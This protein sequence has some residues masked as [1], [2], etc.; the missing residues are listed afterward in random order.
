METPWVFCCLRCR[1]DFFASDTIYDAGS[2]LEFPMRRFLM[3]MGLVFGG[4]AAAML[5]A[6]AQ[7]DTPQQLQ[8]MIANGQAQTALN[9]LQQALQAHPTSGVAWYLT[10]EAQDSLGNESAARAALGN[11]EHFAP[12]LPFANQSDLAA[13]QAHLNSDP[14]PV[15]PV[16]SGISPALVGIIVVVGLFIV[17]R[18]FRRRRYVQPYGQGGFGP[19]YGPGGPGP[20]PYNQGPGMGGSGIGGSILGGLAAGAGFA[21]GE[22]VIGDMFGGNNNNTNNPVDPAWGGNQPMPDRDDG[23]QG[24]PGWDAG[25]TP[26]DG[27][28]FDPNNNW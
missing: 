14:A 21:A 28:N 12:G 20:Y 2:G 17:F 22:R 6:S 19:G 9:E 13:L 27:G 24:S 10:A 16:H 7:S 25:S 11:A 1:M 3:V 5:P 26:D 23:L 4:Y 18:M 8:A 15:Q